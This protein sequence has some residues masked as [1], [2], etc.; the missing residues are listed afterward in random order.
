MFQLLLVLHTFRSGPSHL[1]CENG[2]KEEQAHYPD[3][4]GEGENLIQAKIDTVGCQKGNRVNNECV[5]PLFTASSI[6]AHTLEKKEIIVQHL[7]G[8]IGF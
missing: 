5:Q 6:S 4:A 1:Y 7:E 8:Q 3:K 2:M